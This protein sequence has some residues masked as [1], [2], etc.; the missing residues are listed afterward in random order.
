MKPEEELELLRLKLKILELEKEKELSKSQNIEEL[1]DN[2]PAPIVLQ[3]MRRR[4]IT[5]EELDK[6]TPG[7]LFIL[8]RK[9]G[10]PVESIFP[11]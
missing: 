9:K 7:E 11:I 8:A 6:L 2:E 5:R 3:G 1:V 4:Y 10:I